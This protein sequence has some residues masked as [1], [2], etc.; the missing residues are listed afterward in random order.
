[1]NAKCPRIP[2]G[3]YS[4]DI[5]GMVSLVVLIGIDP[6]REVGVILDAIWRIDIDHLHFALQIFI[7]N[8]RLHHLQGVSADE[9]VLPT[10]VVGIEL[11]PLLLLGFSQR[12]LQVR[13]E[14]CLFWLLGHGLGLASSEFD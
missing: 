12:L 6:L 13:E 2:K 1:M 4:E 8:E 3:L 14:S 7:M 5:V 9:L 10:L 11:D